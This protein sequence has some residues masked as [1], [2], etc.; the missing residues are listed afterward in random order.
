MTDAEIVADKD[1][2]REVFWTNLKTGYDFFEGKKVP[3]D[4]HVVNDGYA[5][6]QACWQ[7]FRADLPG[8]DETSECTGRAALSS[9]EPCIMQRKAQGPSVYAQCPSWQV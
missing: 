9:G 8:S 7:F 1:R 2:S 3:P 6:E 4:A 5:F